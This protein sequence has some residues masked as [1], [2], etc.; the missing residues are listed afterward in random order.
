MCEYISPG[1]VDWICCAIVD[2]CEI[3][4]LNCG[5]N[6]LYEVLLYSCCFAKYMHFFGVRDVHVGVC[7]SGCD[8]Q[9]DE[10]T[11]VSQ[12]DKGCI[13]DEVILRIGVSYAVR[14]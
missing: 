14:F 2:I 4:P 12:V 10:W 8:I 13:Q 11:Q 5:N 3:S 7:L 6:L 1:V 9:Y